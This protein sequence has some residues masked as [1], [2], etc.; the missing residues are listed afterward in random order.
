[1]SCPF[2]CPLAWSNDRGSP[3]G[4]GRSRAGVP[5]NDCP[6]VSPHAHAC[7][8]GGVMCGLFPAVAAGDWR[9]VA[10]CP[11]ACPLARTT[12]LATDPHQHLAYRYVLP[13]KERQKRQRRTPGFGGGP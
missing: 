1:M 3:C 10:S 4:H 12:G 9:G 2:A 8:P 6:W 7:S 11:F 5:T 13:A